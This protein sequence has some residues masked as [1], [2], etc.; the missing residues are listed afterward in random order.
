MPEWLGVSSQLLSR[1][2]PCE[3]PYQGLYCY[4]GNKGPKHH[5]VCHH[6]CQLVCWCWYCLIKFDFQV[7]GLLDYQA[8]FITFIT[9]TSYACYCAWSQLSARRRFV[10]ECYFFIMIMDQIK[11]HNKWQDK[12][13]CSLVSIQG[14]CL[15]QKRD[16]H[17]TAMGW[18]RLLNRGGC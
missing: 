6:S 7:K 16:K 12:M 11:W 2:A 10:H 9:C 8:T 15:I 17:R 13:I 18:P 3:T 5:C 1:K 4:H 14:G